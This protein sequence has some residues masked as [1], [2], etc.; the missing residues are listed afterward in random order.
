VT[1]DQLA[2]E[3]GVNE[4]VECAVDLPWDS[5]LRGQ[6]VAMFVVIWSLGVWSF[7]RVI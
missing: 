7:G 6:M 1:S 5:G 4:A 3:D 2:A